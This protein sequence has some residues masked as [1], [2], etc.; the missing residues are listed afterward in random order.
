MIGSSI[1]RETI[2]EAR[3]LWRGIVMFISLYRPAL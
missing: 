1:F 2:A 3:M